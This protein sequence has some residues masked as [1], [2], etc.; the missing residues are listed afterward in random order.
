M[1]KQSVFSVLCLLL[2]LSIILSACDAQPPPTS[3]P[4]SSATIQPTNT[5][6]PTSTATLLLTSSF[7]PSPTITQTPTTI[8]DFVITRPLDAGSG[9]LREVL[10]NAQPGDIII[11]DSLIFPPDNPVTI[12]LES[13]LP[14]IA[15]GNLSID[16][17]NAGVI[18]DGSNLPSGT[19]GLHITSD[20]NSIK[21]L[22]IINFPGDGI[23]ITNGAKHNT[24]GG[25]STAGNAQKGEGNIITLN[26]NDGVNINGTDT[27][28]N[29]VSGNLIGLD[30]DGTRDIRVQSMAISPDYIS[31]Q[32]LFIST[33]YN[34]VWRTTDGGN[35]WDEVNNGLTIPDVRALVISPDFYTDE[36]LFAGTSDGGIYK[37]TDSG[38]S[39]V[40]IGE[41]LTD[42]DIV[43]LSI[44]P[45][46]TRD[47][48]VFAATQ[49]DGVFVTTNLGESWE[50]QN[51]GISNTWL[52]DIEISPNYG[53]DQTLFTVSW[54]GIYKS[55]DQGESWTMVNNTEGIGALTVSPD[56][57]ND[58]TVFAG[59]GCLDSSILF[60]STNKGEEWTQ[61]GSNPG[62]C[63]ILTLVPSSDYATSKTIFASDQ[64]YGVFKSDDGGASWVNVQPGR[65]NLAIAV[66]LFSSDDE[67]IFVGR[68]TAGGIWKS[69]NGGDEW[70]DIVADLME[71]G[72]GKYGVELWD[73]AQ[74]NI[75]G[76]AN[77]GERNVIS[78]NGK[79]GINI[80]DTETNE[81][82][83]IGNLIGTDPSGTT[84]LGN[85]WQGIILQ[86]E[87]QRNVI[88]GIIESE[89][90]VISGNGERGIHITGSGTTDNIIIGNFIGIDISGSSKLGNVETGVDI[91][92]QASQNQIGG[93]SPTE[94]NIIS[95][96]GSYGVRM[97][98]AD[99]QENIIIGNFIGTDSSG[100]KPL[101]NYRAGVG[102][103]NGAQNNRVGGTS[104][105]ESNLIS[106]NNWSGVY[107]ADIDTTD[108]MIIGN[109]IGT[110]A[111]G[112]IALGNSWGGV[113]CRNNA[114][115]NTF[116]RNVISGNNGYGIRLES[117]DRN[118]ILGNFIGVD[119]SN[120]IQLGNSGDG[121]NLCCGA[122][123]NIIRDQVITFNNESGIQIDNSLFNT[124]TQNSIFN[125]VSRGIDNRN[126]GNNEILPPELTEVTF[127]SVTGK[128][129]YANAIV[130]IFS[131]N[132]DEG[133]FFEGSTTT[134]EWGN[135]F[136]EIEDEFIY[137]CVTATI[138][139]K[140]GNTSNFA[141]SVPITEDAAC[142]LLIL[143][144]AGYEDPKY[145]P[146]FEENHPGVADHIIIWDDAEIL[147]L[148]ND[149]IP[150]DI[151]HTCSWELFYVGGW[152]QPLDPSD[153][154]NWGGVYE[155]MVEWATFNDQLYYAPWDWGFDTILV[156]TDMVD[157]IPE[158]YA[159]LTN[160]EYA[161][162][163]ALFG[164]AEVNHQIAALALGFET[165]EFTPEQEAE[166]EQWLVE[167]K[168]NGFYLWGSENWLT[169]LMVSGDVWIA[170]STWTAY[171]RALIENDIPA[172]YLNDDED[173]RFGWV[174]GYA[175]TS[176]SKNIQL[177]HEYI[178]ALLDPISGATLANDE[179][180]SPANK[181]SIPLIDPDLA[182]FL[183]LFDEDSLL[184]SQTYPTIT[185][186]KLQEWIAM[187]ERVLS[188][189]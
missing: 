82:I 93:T 42:K 13:A 166:I 189:P 15:H 77:T 92:S 145:Y 65:Y 187:W 6:V 109:L 12:V 54:S 173:L 52:Y 183:K 118:T 149:G 136:F 30:S 11:F 31:D 158:S 90:N 78:H 46:Y 179:W 94:R 98:G 33:K 160:L 41:D 170:T 50:K 58:G 70:A 64:W 162:H 5:Q 108:N 1:N 99:I 116:G 151:V 44:S 153:L 18:L 164:S 73:G 85:G 132:L 71:H 72:N 3:I 88:G 49:G 150:A 128:S 26:G 154:S 141:R 95:G 144:W 61:F 34:G 114:Q 32:T 47:G 188:D 22:Q 119:S 69:T 157:T 10:L 45:D 171:Y 168:R 60:R 62:W 79:A 59:T 56:F 184:R 112:E 169:P 152:I 139:D 2:S 143:E 125:N 63:N 76:G 131:D 107:L 40:Q 19:D 110:D 177:A 103:F 8:P 102:I 37:T 106:S 43:A 87:V 155:L 97:S 174:C 111:S 159:D 17:S 48:H 55:N 172:V 175:I 38:N 182:E 105:A 138:T 4:T 129:S 29:I 123:E 57:A 117:C 135:F 167:L 14:E 16:A 91:E 121:M 9:S 21:G 66:Y 178:D 86:S 39:W 180:Y 81:N 36:T 7:T 83:I 126:G 161:G 148:L 146:E 156:R 100:L 124:I 133:Q 101:G 147:D 23:E 20:G 134:D 68:G 165:D 28:N 163:I 27:T 24:I 89:R 185:E 53:E 74:E 142:G 80:H 67:T 104:P 137:S 176:T 75:I 113:Y 186:E 130:E 115:Q 181:R 96:N 120:T 122:D 51:T 140:E 127:K 25:N 84:A 35:N